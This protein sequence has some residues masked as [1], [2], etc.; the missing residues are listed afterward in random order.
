VRLVKLPASDWV[1]NA[2]FSGEEESRN[3]SGD[4]PEAL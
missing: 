1:M 3:S 2:K 4:V